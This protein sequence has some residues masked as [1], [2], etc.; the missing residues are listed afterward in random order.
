MIGQTISHYRILEELGSGGMGVVYKAEDLKLGRCVVL[1]FLNPLLTRDEQAKARF[2][3]EAKAASALDH[4]NVCTIYEIDE[5]EAGQMFIVMAYY[6]GET[7]EKNIHHA[8]LQMNEAINIALQIANGLS[9]THAANVIHRD[10]KPS[11]IIITDHGEIKIID[12]GLAKLGGYSKLTQAGTMLGTTAYMSPEQL[13]GDFVDHRSDIFSFGV[14]LYETLTGKHPFGEN[15]QAMAYSIVNKEPETVR[16]IRSDLPD[17]LERIVNRALKKAPEERYQSMGELRTDLVSVCKTSEAD[18]TM[19]ASQKIKRKSTSIARP[20]KLV[21]FFLVFMLYY[22]PLLAFVFLLSQMLVPGWCPDV[23]LYGPWSL[24]LLIANWFETSFGIAQPAATHWAGGITDFPVIIIHLLCALQIWF[25]KGLWQAESSSGTAHYSIRGFLRWRKD[26]WT[27]VGVI[28]VLA[29]IALTI[30]HQFLPDTTCHVFGPTAK[31]L[32]ANLRT[33]IPYAPDERFFLMLHRL[34]QLISLFLFLLTSAYA[35]PAYLRSSLSRPRPMAD[36]NDKEL[37]VEILRT[38]TIPLFGIGIVLILALMSAELGIDEISGRSRHSA[39][40]AIFI[41][42]F[43]LASG[44]FR[45]VRVERK[46]LDFF[47]WLD[48]VIQRTRAVSGKLFRQFL[49]IGGVAVFFVLIMPRL[50]RMTPGLAAIDLPML[51]LEAKVRSNLM[52]FCA[53]N[54]KKERNLY[55][56]VCQQI[57]RAMAGNVGLHSEKPRQ[58]LESQ[59]IVQAM[60]IALF[61]HDV[62]FSRIIRGK[63]DSIQL[64]KNASIEEILI[65]IEPL[66]RDFERLSIPFFYDADYLAAHRRISA[67][68]LLEYLKSNR[69]PLR[70]PAQPELEISSERIWEMAE[71]AYRQ[72]L[73]DLHVLDLIKSK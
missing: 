41:L 34:L 68:K 71:L 25:T 48:R 2:A 8:P 23:K 32:I 55:S 65:E 46:D 63:A 50:M 64:L 20:N 9:A 47:V 3:N 73:S 72:H 53:W 35:L 59:V 10:I 7:L 1:K 58:I 38:I 31:G 29:A 37:R 22:G 39:A 15:D 60:F 61:H 21:S 40:I 24:R 11:N 45:L 57:D 26:G 13:R 12:F 70:P 51:E 67:Y 5:S 49:T 6:N 16:S 69:I 4:P 52:D 18:S 17:E 42:L 66:V 33:D 19:S 43:W 14:V 27:L 54:M 62:Q 30:Y 28:A 36:T 56:Y 44:L